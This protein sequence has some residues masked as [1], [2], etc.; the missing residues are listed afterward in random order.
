MVCTEEGDVYC[1]GDNDEGQLGDGT[2]NAGQ[3]PKLSSV[4]QVYHSIIMRV[5]KITILISFL[6]SFLS[7]KV[8]KIWVT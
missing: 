8:R 5:V 7:E 6:T 4:L 2:T 1:W 3:L